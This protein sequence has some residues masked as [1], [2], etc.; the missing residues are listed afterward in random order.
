MTTSLQLDQLVQRAESLPKLPAMSVRLIG[1]V[2]DPASTLEQIVDIIRYDQ[3]VTTRLL[4]MCNSAYA[5]LARPITS[6][7]EA[8]RYVGT[9]ELLRLVMAAH[10]QTLL[11]PAQSGYGLRPGALWSHSVGVALGC[12]AV[13][14]RLGVQEKGVLFTVG[15]L[16]DIGKIILNEHVGVEYGR[17]THLVNQ[18]SVSFAEAEQR[19]L[20]VTHTE[21]GEL[22]ARRWELP[23][24]IPRCVRYHHEPSAPPSPDV[25]IDAVHV[26]DAACLVFG[27]GGGDDSQMYRVDQAVLERNGLKTND[28]EKLGATVVHELKSVKRLLGV[29]IE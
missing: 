18:E 7:D 9:A 24:P 21:I 26:A 28:I 2:N 20:G 15:L 8:V 12:Q 23:D 3:T 11:A 25:L 14:D 19:V 10:T 29:E 17:I 16:H 22:V 27:I 6:I 5:S 1:A 13:A 4:R